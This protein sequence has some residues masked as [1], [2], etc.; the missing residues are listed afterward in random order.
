MVTDLTRPLYKDLGLKL[1][2]QR[3]MPLKSLVEA[4]QWLLQHFLVIS[5]ALGQDPVFLNVDVL[6]NIVPK[7]EQ[8]V[9]NLPNFEDSLVG[10]NS[11]SLGV[12]DRFRQLVYLQGSDRLALCF[13]LP[14]LAQL[15][16]FSRR[17]KPVELPGDLLKTPIDQPGVSRAC[18][19][20]L[21]L[22]LAHQG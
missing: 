22:F 4:G 5:L 16:L 13:D 3:V 21:D 10:G 7:S 8:I 12:G 9:C 17:G 11:L 1:A 6:K 14:S 15:F 19:E 2:L 20:L 18:L